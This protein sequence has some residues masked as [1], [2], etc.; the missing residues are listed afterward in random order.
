MGGEHTH[1]HRQQA[2]LVTLSFFLSRDKSRLHMINHLHRTKKTILKKPVLHYKPVA[3]T[4]TQDAK[5]LDFSLIQSN[6]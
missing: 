5:R 4:E 6:P 1:T 2:D 3:F